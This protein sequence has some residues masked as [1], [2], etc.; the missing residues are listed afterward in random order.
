MSQ[1]FY[2][3]IDFGIS[4]LLHGIEFV[5]GI[6]ATYKRFILNLMPTVQ[7]PHSQCFDTQIEMHTTAYNSDVILSQ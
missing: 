6:N 2:I 4:E 7:L 1:A 5:D 3:I